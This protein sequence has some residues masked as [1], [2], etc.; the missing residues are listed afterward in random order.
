[1]RTFHL[2]IA[3]V[4]TNLFDGEA[5]SVSLP[6]TEGVFEVLAEHEAFVAEL[7]SGNIRVTNAEG[8]S[9]TFPIGGGVAEVSRNQATVLLS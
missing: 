1:M 6:G 2:T 7:R 5:A 9:Q 8:A 3:K 4:G